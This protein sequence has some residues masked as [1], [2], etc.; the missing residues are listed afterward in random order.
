MLVTLEL[1]TAEWITRMENAND[2]DFIQAA[3]NKG[4]LN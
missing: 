1:S 3:K 2:T 4:M